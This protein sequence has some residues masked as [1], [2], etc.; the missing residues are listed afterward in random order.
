M[1]GPP[2]FEHNQQDNIRAREKITETAIDEEDLELILILDDTD[3]Q[4]DAQQFN[5]RLVLLL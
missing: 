4:K 3:A 1:H 5:S 2:I